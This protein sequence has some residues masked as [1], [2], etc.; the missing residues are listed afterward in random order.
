MMKVSSFLLFCSLCIITTHAD[1]DD[2]PFPDYN[3]GDHFNCLYHSSDNQWHCCGYVANGE[4]HCSAS[5]Q[6]DIYQGKPRRCQTYGGNNDNS[7]P[8]PGDDN[9]QDICCEDSRID[10]CGGNCKAFYIWD[11]RSVDEVVTVTTD[12]ETMVETQ[13]PVDPVSLDDDWRDQYLNQGLD[14]KDGYDNRVYPVAFAKGTLH[15]NND[16]PVCV[17]IPG[18][19][20]RVIEIKVESEGGDDRLCVDDTHD[21]E[22][23]KNDPGQTKTCDAGRLTTCFSDAS[24]MAGKTGFAFIINCD[25][26]CEETSD[27][28]VWFRAR[29]S[30]YGWVDQGVDGNIY[31]DQNVEMWCDYVQRDYPDFD[32]FP[33]D[34]SPQKAARV[35]QP[36]SVAGLS[37]LLSFLGFLLF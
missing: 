35:P 29:F 6:W 1:A 15:Y 23:D 7:L 5:N 3:Y 10:S 36:A 20:G 4:Y 24:D 9:Y 31:A 37:V 27:V 33:S 32:A 17:Y 14:T 18:S 16:P 11:F 22:T 19:A 34:L 21:D 13:T 2:D 25:G 26:S 28:Q 30:E 8:R 12:P